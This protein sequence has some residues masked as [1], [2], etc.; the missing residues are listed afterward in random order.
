[1][2]NYDKL[3]Q[4]TFINN[5]CTDFMF[6]EVMMCETCSPLILSHYF[7]FPFSFQDITKVS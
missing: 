1:M 3:L 7:Q 4:M 5:Y 6:Q 2:K